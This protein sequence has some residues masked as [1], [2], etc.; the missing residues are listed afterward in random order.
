MHIQDGV[1]TA[2]TAGTVLLALGWVGAGLGT[3]L[4]LSRLDADQ[5]PRTGL[6]TSL[7][8]V[9]SLIQV[10]VGPISVH[11]VLNGLLGLIL[12][13][14]AFPAVLIALL[15]QWLFF[16]MGGLTTLG[17]NTV[18]MALPAVLARY[19]FGRLVCSP[20]VQLV[21]LGGF[22]VGA[23][24]V[25]LA[26]T[27]TALSVAVAGREFVVVSWIVWIGDGVIAVGEGIVTAAAVVFLRRV[28]P[29]V[30]GAAILEGRVPAW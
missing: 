5:V 8:F 23:V 27:M 25:L 20:R 21:A 15:L 6:L 26:A 30:F 12:G 28:Y 22:G 24:T 17:I 14:T 3:T 7:F 1:L 10:P 19:A 18:N 16:G 2:S 4:G 29:Q 11:L 9:V 13:W